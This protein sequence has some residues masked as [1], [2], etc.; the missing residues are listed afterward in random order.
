MTIIIIVKK[1][2]SYLKPLFRNYKLD[3]MIT[4]AMQRI[5]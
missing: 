3:L 1:F 4:E 2:K 5:T